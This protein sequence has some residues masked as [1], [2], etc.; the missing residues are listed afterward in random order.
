MAKLAIK[1]GTIIKAQGT[2]IE[3]LSRDTQPIT[4]VK[5]A[6]GWLIRVSNSEQ[7]Q[8]CDL[9]NMKKLLAYADEVVDPKGLDMSDDELLAAVFA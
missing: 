5:W 2:E 7:V 6:N 4:P 1:S 3:V 8:F 9:R